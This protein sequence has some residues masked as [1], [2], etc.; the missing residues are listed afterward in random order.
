MKVNS[1]GHVPDASALLAASTGGT[2]LTT[3]KAW[4]DLKLEV[5]VEQARLGRAT[6]SC[7]YFSRVTGA[8][9]LGRFAARPGLR[10]S[11]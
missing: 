5:R 4:T 7:F 9:F 6:R 1:A 11:N 2:V 10:V 3:D 8:V